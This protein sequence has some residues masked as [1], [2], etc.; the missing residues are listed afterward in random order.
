MASISS[1]NTLRF[2]TVSND[3]HLLSTTPRLNDCQIYNY[4]C[5]HLIEPISFISFEVMPAHSSQTYL[6]NNLKV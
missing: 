1:P 2:R 4:Y 5:Y 6:F 3:Q